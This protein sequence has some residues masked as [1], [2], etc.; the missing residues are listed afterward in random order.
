MLA[1]IVTLAE[2]NVSIVSMMWTAWITETKD[3]EVVEGALK[4]KT[5]EQWGQ[6][7]LTRALLKALDL[8]N[9]LP[10]KNPVRLLQL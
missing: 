10:T 7:M 9:F 3:V 8:K 6:Q 2:D 4:V 1:Q 5:E